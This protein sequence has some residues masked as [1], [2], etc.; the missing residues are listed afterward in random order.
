MDK[1]A[2]DIQYDQLGSAPEDGMIPIPLAETK[3]YDAIPR[4]LRFFVLRRHER[5]VK[6]WY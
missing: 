6:V 2:F 4:G 1:S 3:Y 5:P